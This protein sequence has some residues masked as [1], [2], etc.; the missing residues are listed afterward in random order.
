MPEKFQQLPPTQLPPPPQ[1][2]HLQILPEEAMC[3]L[4]N[5]S[6]HPLPTSA[7]SQEALAVT[8]ATIKYGPHLQNVIIPS[9]AWKA[10]VDFSCTESKIAHQLQARRRWPS[11]FNKVLYLAVIFSYTATRSMERVNR[12]IRRVLMMLCLF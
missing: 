1:G 4:S 2:L 7:I 10:C 3:V 5:T 11:A 6:E 9:A 12:C 8:S